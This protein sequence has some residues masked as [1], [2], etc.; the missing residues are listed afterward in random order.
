MLNMRGR[1]FIHNDLVEITKLAATGLINQP[2]AE[3]S[4]CLPERVFQS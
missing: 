2:A 4:I 1:R 3:S